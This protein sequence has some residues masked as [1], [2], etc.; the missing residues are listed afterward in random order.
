MLSLHDILHQLRPALRITGQQLLVLQVLLV[1]DRVRKVPFIAFAVFLTHFEC[2][3]NM[4][5]CS[6]NVDLVRQRGNEI[7]IELILAALHGHIGPCAAKH[8][9]ERLHIAAR[10]SLSLLKALLEESALELPVPDHR[11]DQRQQ[12][13]CLQLCHKRGCLIKVGASEDAIV[14]MNPLPR[15]QQSNERAAQRAAIGCAD[16]PAAVFLDVCFYFCGFLQHS[17]KLR[18]FRFVKAVVADAE[19]AIAVRQ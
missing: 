7:G 19:N 1:N 2:I 11:I 6:R 5:L 17:R 18:A 15:R 16:M 12:Q 4:N 13:I 14:Y 9:H 10:F 3:E 8:I